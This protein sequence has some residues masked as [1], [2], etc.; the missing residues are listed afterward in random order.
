MD[1]KQKYL[2]YKKKYLLLKEKIGGK[3]EG[4]GS[5]GLVMSNP[6][7]PLMDETYNS[8]KDLNQVS[9]ILYIYDNNTD[10]YH[11]ATKD[12]Y[13]KEFND[14]KKYIDKY[15]TIFTFDNFI[16]PVSGGMINIKEFINN[17]IY[18]DKWYENTSVEKIFYDLFI[19]NR[20]P[21]YQL[22]AELR[23]IS[24]I[25]NLI[26][27]QKNINY[28]ALMTNPISAINKMHIN[29]MF[30]KD[31]KTDNMIFHDNKIKIS[32]WSDFFDL[33]DKTTQEKINILNDDQFIQNVFYFVNSPIASVLLC[34][35]SN[36][37]AIKTKPYNEPINEYVRGEFFEYLYNKA[38]DPN[39]NKYR[40]YLLSV[41][42]RIK[43]NLGHKFDLVEVKFNAYDWSTNFSKR[44]NVSF[45]DLWNSIYPLYELNTVSNSNV[46]KIFRHYKSYL[47]AKLTTDEILKNLL[48]TNNMFAIGQT[49]MYYLDKC[50]TEGIPLSDDIVTNIMKIIIFCLGRV[51]IKDNKI[52]ISQYTL[53]DIHIFMTI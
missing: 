50:L 1:F 17:N 3:V 5:F 48:K 16:L 40:S 51:I 18:D 21:T 29:N 11:P 10:T 28:Y 34:L 4:M 35:Y 30:L 42:G 15:P 9:K 46:E 37:I 47:D 32:D 41:F 13:N 14:I 31:I 6:R 12:M 20:Y 33:N 45:N 52:Y 53:N 43:T 23:L 44:I 19:L 25:N 26:E 24:A 49:F 38:L 27:T 39:D 36:T 2:K 7:L 22:S 8:I